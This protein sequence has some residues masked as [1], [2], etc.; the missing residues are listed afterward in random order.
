MKIVDQLTYETYVRKYGVVHCTSG[1]PLQTIEESFN[2]NGKLIAEAI[3]NKGLRPV[4]KI[5]IK[6]LSK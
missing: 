1:T 6:E 5:N 4:Y 2:A 3:Y